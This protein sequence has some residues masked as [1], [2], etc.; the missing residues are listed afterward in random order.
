MALAS[1]AFCTAAAA[2]AGA[3]SF[4]FLLFLVEAGFFAVAAGFLAEADGFFGD[5]ACF[6]AAEAGFLEAAAGILVPTGFSPAAA[7]VS[8]GLTSSSSSFKNSKDNLGI[9]ILLVL[10]Q[11]MQ[12]VKNI[13]IYHNIKKQQNNITYFMCYFDKIQLIY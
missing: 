4:P 3:G 12:Y 9:K 5:A 1:L 2:R 10:L 7:F 11:C 6:F 8:G 13:K